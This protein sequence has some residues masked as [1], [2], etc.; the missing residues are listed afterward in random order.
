VNKTFWTVEAKIPFSALSLNGQY[1]ATPQKGD[2]WGVL[3]AAIRAR[4]TNGAAGL[5]T[6]LNLRTDSIRSKTSAGLFLW[7]GKAAPNCRWSR[8]FPRRRLSMEEY[9]EILLRGQAAMRFCAVARRE[10]GGRE[11]DRR[12]SGIRSA[13]SG[14]D[15]GNL[16]V[17]MSF[18]QGEQ[19]VYNFYYEKRL[20]PAKQLFAR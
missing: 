16:Q 17:S 15:G 7:D 8:S 6:A 19:N 1:A 3:F 11:E 10:N 14:A 9:F 5:S 12:I 4:S 2:A 18:F 13:V 20:S